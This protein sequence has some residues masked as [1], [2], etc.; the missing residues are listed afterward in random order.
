MEARISDSENQEA[1]RRIRK[2]RSRIRWGKTLDNF[3]RPTSVPPS[4]WDL[5]GLHR[6]ADLRRP[7][8]RPLVLCHRVAS[9][10]TFFVVAGA[11]WW[12]FK[13]EYTCALKDKA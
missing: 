6:V 5:A 9:A 10:I 13:Y 12:I 1:Q 2:E 7:S 4:G 11:K 8:G 3:W